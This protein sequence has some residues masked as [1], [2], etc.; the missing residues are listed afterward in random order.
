MDTL[1]RAIAEPRRR[2][3]LQLVRNRELSAGEIAAAF[4]VSRPAV[5]QHLKVLGDAGLLTVRKA[6]TRRLYRVRPE[7]IAELKAFLDTWWEGG[8]ERLK[9]SA[10]A[11]AEEERKRNDG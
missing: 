6:G 10:E 4:A 9:A 2:R 8:L 7:A 1:L 5:S 3:I 11:E